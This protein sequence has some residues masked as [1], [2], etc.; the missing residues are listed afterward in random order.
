[1]PRLKGVAMFK[2]LLISSL[3]FF[4]ADEQLKFMYGITVFLS[5]GNRKFSHAIIRYRVMF[6]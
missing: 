1:M 5:F 3:T 2:W 4:A 6:Y